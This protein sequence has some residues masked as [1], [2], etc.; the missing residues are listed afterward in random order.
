MTSSSTGRLN[1]ARIR[2]CQ[3][4]TSASSLRRPRASLAGSGRPDFRHPVQRGEEVV[5]HA[6]LAGEHGPAGTGQLVIAAP[7]LTGALDPAP[8]DQPAIL[9]PVEGGIERG[10]VEVDRPL[11]PAGDQLS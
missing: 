3:F 7:A 5:P 8:F 2:L 1:S 9:E 10:D 6:A 4:I 11:G